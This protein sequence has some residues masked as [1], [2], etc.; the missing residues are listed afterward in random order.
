M[1][2]AADEPACNR[3]KIPQ[4]NRRVAGRKCQGAQMNRQIPPACR[5]SDVQILLMRQMNQR[6]A[7]DEPACR[8]NK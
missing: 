7:A 3:Q 1:E 6:A 4:M 5:V 8:S 2:S